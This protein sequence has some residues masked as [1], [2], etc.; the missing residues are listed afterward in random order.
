MSVFRFLAAAGAMCLAAASA[1]AQTSYP[2]ACQGGPDMRIMVNHDV[3]SAGKPGATA[4]F[5]YFRAAGTAAQPGPG[6][7]VWMDRTFRPGEPEVLWLR[8]PDIEF[9]FQV[10]GDGTVVQDG[11]GHRLNVEGAHISPEAASWDRIVKAV[12][13]GGTFEV[14][15]YNSE[16]R[17]MVV[18]GVR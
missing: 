14:D 15:V 16:N 1:Q 12:L 2:L 6:E 3:D 13:T 8:S 18:T 7:C 11:S 4:M 17:V 9:A 5:V 10:M